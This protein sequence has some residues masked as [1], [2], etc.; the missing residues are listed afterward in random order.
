VLDRVNRSS[1]LW[2]QYAFLCDLVE[3]DGETFRYSEEVPLD[4]VLDG[5]FGAGPRF[6]IVTLEYG[7]GH[8]T[9]DPFDVEVG[10]AWEADPAN[11]DRYLHP[12]IRYYEQGE[13]VT[14]LHLAEDVCNDWSS[15]DR[16]R[17]PLVELLADVVVRPGAVAR[18]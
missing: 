11:P 3:V 6:V 14:E 10:R 16:H 18:A 7:P 15:D 4:H 17:A 13:L 2:Q 12:V 8:D 1:G 9:I 5:G